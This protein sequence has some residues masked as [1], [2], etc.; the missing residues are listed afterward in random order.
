MPHF[1]RPVG[2]RFPAVPAALETVVSWTRK[3][4]CLCL[5]RISTHPLFV[6]VLAQNFPPIEFYAEFPAH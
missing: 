3:Q 6:H 2:W 4:S 5:P 1:A